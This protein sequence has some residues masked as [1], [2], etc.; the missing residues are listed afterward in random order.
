VPFGLQQLVSSGRLQFV[1]R[2]ITDSKFSPGRDMGT[3]FAGRTAADRIGYEVGVFNGSGESIRQTTAAPIWAARVFVEPAGA[4]ALAES[5]VDAGGGLVWHA[6]LAIRG[7]KQIRGRTDPDVFDDADD[8]RAVDI[9]LVVRTPVVFATSELF[10]M[11]D[12]QENPTRGPDIR[13]RGFHVQGGYMVV[14]GATEV[15]LRYARVDG[16]T[17]VDDASVT[18]LLGV[19]GHYF[20]AHSLKLQVD[21]GRIFYGPNFLLLSSRA[22]AGLPILGPRLVTGESIS[23]LQV[24]A[25]LQLAF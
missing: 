7:G 10:W 17:D 15:G 24:R 9:E 25:Q 16:N 11:T 4:I 14:P 13:S 18:E 3:M 12:E 19:V 21:A 1:D 2:S 8:Q 22:R 23:D 5:A 20:R 6:G